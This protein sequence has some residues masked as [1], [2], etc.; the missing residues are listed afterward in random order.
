MGEV[1]TDIAALLAA[2]KSSGARIACLCS[3]DKIYA[4]EAADAARALTASDAVVHLAGRPGEH[5][6]AWNEAGVS[7]YIFVGCD[8]LAT[9]TAA[10]DKVSKS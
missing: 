7:A 8:A 4:M 6:A 9:L 2:F 5:E 3:A 1:K 10:Y